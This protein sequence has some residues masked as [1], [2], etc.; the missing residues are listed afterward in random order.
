MRSHEELLAYVNSPKQSG[1]D[2]LERRQFRISEAIL[3]V[4]CDLRDLQVYKS[5]AKGTAK[6]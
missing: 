2:P 4:L 5:A 6:N 3:E 1:F